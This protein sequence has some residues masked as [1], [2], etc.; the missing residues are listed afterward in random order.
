MFP[1]KQARRDATHAG[2]ARLELTAMVTAFSGFL[3]YEFPHDIEQFD[4][5]DVQSI[6]SSGLTKRLR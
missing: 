5:H 3:S 6:N 4:Q 2:M 1:E